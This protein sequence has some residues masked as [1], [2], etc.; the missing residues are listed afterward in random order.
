MCSSDLGRR[1]VDGEHDAGDEPTAVHDMGGKPMSRGQLLREPRYLTM[2]GAFSLG[3]LAQ[4]SFIAHQVAYLEPT[5]GLKGAGWAVSATSLSAL[6]GRLAVGLVI[7]R[8]DRRGTSAA[9]LCVQVSS[10]IVLLASDSLFGLYLG[11]ILF[12]FGVGNLIT[13]PGLIVQQE[14]PRRD[15]ARAVS[16]NVAINQLVAATGPSILGILHDLS[17]SYRTSLV[18]CLALQAA[19]AALVLV[20]PRPT[21]SDAET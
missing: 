21:V 18:A 12:G 2:V 5:L 1:F 3:L 6:V 9:V 8:V 19:A 16:L 4:I 14:F 7:D 11:C 17:G 13:L 20:R 10:M 15:F